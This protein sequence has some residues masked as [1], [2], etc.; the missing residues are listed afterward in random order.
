VRASDL[1]PGGYE[2][3]FKLWEC[4][5]DLL[6]ELG[7]RHRDGTLRASGAS[8]L[9]AG[10]GAGLPSLLALQLGCRVAVLHDFNA[11]AHL[12]SLLTSQRRAE[13][14]AV[15]EAAA[16]S[17]SPPLPPDGFDLILTSDTIYDAGAARRLW[18]LIASQLRRPVGL[19]L[20]A[21]KSYYFGV[22]GSVAAFRTLVEEDGRFSCTSAR[23]V[24][25]GA[26][27]RREVLLIR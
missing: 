14:A 5:V 22:G 17:S 21:A 16:P 24:E 11:E 23:V 7:A 13:A 10:C 27:N 12:D 15:V 20:V 1:V 2:G 9:E 8:V 25:D 19:A 3:G 26:S 18:H 4:A 6:H